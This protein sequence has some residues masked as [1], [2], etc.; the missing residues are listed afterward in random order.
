[1]R[2]RL[3]D[4]SGFAL[5]VALGVAIVMTIFVVSVIS[6]VTSNQRSAQI[7]SA[8]LQAAHYAEGALNGAFSILNHVNTN[9]TNATSPNLLGCAVGYS[10]P[11]ISDCSNPTPD[12][13]C[14]AAANC[15]A[16]GDGSGTVY[17]FFSGTN[18]QTFNG[19]A[20]PASTWLLYATGYARNPN[21]NGVVAKQAMALVKISPPF[22]TQQQVASVWNHVFVTAPA[23]NGCSL[24]FAG[25]SVTI[26][27]PMYVI[28]NLCLGSG[29]NGAHITETTQ[30]IDIQVGGKL[31]LSGGSNVGANSSHPITSGVVNGGCTTV[32]VTSTTLP[33]SS[34]AFSYWVKTTDTWIPNDSPVK[35][36]AQIANDYASFDPG[37]KHPCQA[38]GPTF[39]NDTVQNGSNASFELT[40]PTSYT[41]VS[42]NGAGVG[43]LSWNAGT[44]TLT[45]NGSIF[46]DGDMTISA[47]AKYVGVAVIETAGTITFIG[48][49][50]SLCAESPCNTAANAW[51]GSSG[52]NSMLSLVSLTPNGTAIHVT[53]NSQN[54][55]GSMF[56]QPSANVTFDKNGVIIEGPMSIGT[57][58][59][60]FNNATLIPFPVINNMPLGAPLPPN[61]GATISQLTYLK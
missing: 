33:C 43:Q 30:P 27:T 39:D 53:G 48:N 61:A 32:S 23:S 19:I 28:G 4:E 34:G 51:Q 24:S 3:Q 29:G 21:S 45:V 16:G 41:C 54:F 13:F 26:T 22:L 18:P 11:G 38:G 20:V 17:G 25:N 56:T 44:Q 14:V 9:G 15:S 50:H 40:P 10:S 1:M 52:N 42:Q 8:D 37:P 36:S 57:F 6:Y 49:N 2:A 46:I 5:V 60:S 35:T 55:Q 47:S 7:S 59:S 58:D 31:V 12:A